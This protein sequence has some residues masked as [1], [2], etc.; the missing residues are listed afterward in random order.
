MG[1]QSSDFTDEE[2]SKSFENIIKSLTKEGD[3]P[4][5]LASISDTEAAEIARKIYILFCGLAA[6]NTKHELQKY[7]L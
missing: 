1:L 6:T 7:G 4:K 3:I 2:D 5:T